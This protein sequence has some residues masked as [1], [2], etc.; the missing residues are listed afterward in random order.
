MPSSPQNAVF[1]TAASVGQKIISLAYF[2]I[3]AR[4]LGPQDTG[5]Y[6]FALSF[7]TL[8]VVLVDLGLANVLIRE[9]ARTKERIAEYLSTILGMKAFLG[10]IA[11]ALMLLSVNAM[12]YDAETRLLVS[13]SGVTMLFDSANLSLFG[14]LRAL[15]HLSY[16][17]GGMVA[18]QACTLILGTL[19]LAFDMPLPYLLAAFTIPSM[20]NSCFAA[21]VLRRGFGISPLPRFDVALARSFARIA[22]PFALAAVFARVYSY[23]DSILLSK[24]AGHAAVGWYGI[25]TKTAVAFQFIPSALVAAIYPRFCESYAGNRKGVSSL[26]FDSMKYLSIVAIPISLGIAILAEDIV[27]L[28]YSRE[29]MPAVLPLQL[30]IVG[31]IFSFMSFPIGALLNACNRQG[32]Q[33][34]IVGGVMAVNIAMNLALVPAHAAAGAAL[35]GLVCNILLVAAGYIAASRTVGL[36]HAALALSVA[37]VSFAGCAMAASVFLLHGRFPLGIVIAAGAMIYSFLLFAVRAVHRSDLRTLAGLFR[38]V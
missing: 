16:E 35:A 30:L 14:A 19:V 12:G 18:S 13:I 1:M 7:T 36:H 28:L 9:S 4:A 2:I 26:F 37:R 33:T 23:I 27:L 8:F 10:V 17:A 5:K 31:M 15:G 20:L 24:I 29:Y 25:A 32:I 38:R 34:T 21:L 6:V 11:Y 22:V 3:L